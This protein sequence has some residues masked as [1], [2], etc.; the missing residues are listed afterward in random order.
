MSRNSFLKI[1]FAGIIFVF[2]IMLLSLCIG[3]YFIPP[4]EVLRILISN[5]FAIDITWNASMYN[6]IMELRLPRILAGF[7]VGG[8]LALAGAVY[9]GAFRNP[10]VSPD[11]LGVSH[12]ASA[13][14]CLAILGHFSLVGIQAFAFIGGIIAVVIALLIP[15]CMKN[16][17][18]LLLVLSGIIVA[19]F[20]GALIGLMKYMANPDNELADITYWQLGSLAKVSWGNLLYVAPLMIAISLLLFAMRW[21]MNVISLHDK[22][23]KSM[24]VNIHRER[25]GVILAA[26]LLTASSVC[27]SGTIGWVGLI[28]PHLARLFAGGNHVRLFPL[29]FIL[30][31]GFLV[32]IDMLSRTLTQAEIPLGILC[33]FVG[34][35][36]FVWILVKQRRQL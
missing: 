10:L 9:Q 1:L 8:S 27:L 22:E 16:E 30:S 20:M 5:F 11:V 26:T 29:A 3:R 13:G 28:M 17:S 36:F 33:G 32:F 35:P 14:A 19:G 6:V 34:A 24:G 7:L 18:Q 31:G 25:I 23:A 2:L 21:R 15:K 4:E 12:G